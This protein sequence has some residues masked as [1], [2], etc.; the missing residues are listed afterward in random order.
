[1]AGFRVPFGRPLGLILHIFVSLFPAQFYVCILGGEKD[2]VTHQM[3]RP[4]GMRG[5]GWFNTC[6]ILQRL[7]NVDACLTCCSPSARGAAD[8]ELHSHQNGI[9][10]RGFKGLL[11]RTVLKWLL[12]GHLAS[13]YVCVFDLRCVV[14]LR[15]QF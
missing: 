7:L 11:S 13:F 3:G 1:M 10:F 9:T 8:S 14:S 15:A 5:A 6:R 4:G 12:E 2:E